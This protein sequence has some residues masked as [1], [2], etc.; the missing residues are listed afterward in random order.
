MRG[1]KQGR[2]D[3][4]QDKA[5][6]Q[7][8]NQQGVVGTSRADRLNQLGDFILLA[9]GGGA[10]AGIGVRDLVYC[11]ANDAVGHR[12]LQRVIRLVDFSHQVLNEDSS[13]GETRKNHEKI[14]LSERLEVSFV[15][16]GGDDR[17]PRVEADE[18]HDE[19][20]RHVLDEPELGRFLVLR[21]VHEGF[22][23]IF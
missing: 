12:D 14:H 2:T 17:R 3:E 22:V 21:V 20:P 18:E 15:V 7:V 8:E 19:G 9:L 23:H 5:R 4:A 1:P 13:Q 10:P 11:E 6:A 16:N